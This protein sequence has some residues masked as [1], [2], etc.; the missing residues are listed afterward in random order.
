MCSNSTLVP[1]SLGWLWWNKNSF[2]L[3]KSFSGKAWYVP[4]PL[5]VQRAIIS[6]PKYASL[7]R[8]TARV[9]IFEMVI[10][11]G[12]FSTTSSGSSKIDLL[13]AGSGFF[14]LSAS[15]FF[16]KEVVTEV[17]VTEGVLLEVEASSEE[18]VLEMEA[19]FEEGVLLGV[20]ASF[21]EGVLEME[22]AFD[23]G[24]FMAE[25]TLGWLVKSFKVRV[26]VV[27][28]VKILTGGCRFGSCFSILSR[29]L[30]I[31]L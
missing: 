4:V 20:E 3:D 19:A 12:Y 15:I 22:A 26:G 6:F 10:S 16:N 27:T 31:N 17:A 8:R 14:V 28:V 2:N 30:H 18:G 1:V 11:F 9:G 25:S 29:R 7:L 5:T 13:I 21:E 23:G 24:V